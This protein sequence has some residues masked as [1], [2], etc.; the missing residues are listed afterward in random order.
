MH[1]AGP[2]EDLKPMITYRTSKERVYG[3]PCYPVEAKALSPSYSPPPLRT[4]TLRP[5]PKAVTSTRVPRTPSTKATLISH[6][7]NYETACRIVS[8]DIHRR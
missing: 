6:P 7:R 4:H 1:N 5:L 2:N 8:L 3:N